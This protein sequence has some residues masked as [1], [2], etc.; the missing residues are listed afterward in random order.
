MMVKSGE[1]Y[2]LELRRKLF[3]CH[4][5]MN[6]HTLKAPPWQIAQYQ[7]P[8]L[9]QLQ[10]PSW[11][12][13]TR[14]V[15]VFCFH[16]R[17][18]MYLSVCPLVCASCLSLQQILLHVHL[19]KSA[20]SHS[21][22]VRVSAEDE[23]QRVCRKVWE[24]RS[25]GKSVCVRGSTCSHSLSRVPWHGS[26]NNPLGWGRE[27]VSVEALMYWGGKGCPAPPTSYSSDW[28]H[29]R[30]TLNHQESLSPLHT[31]QHPW[32]C[33]C[34]CS[35]YMWAQRGG[36]SE[37]LEAFSF[38]PGSNVTGVVQ[39]KFLAAWVWSCRNL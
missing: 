30:V 11:W 14:F 7:D 12:R 24:R 18:Q 21:T 6:T 3:Q 5:G 10:Y 35:A 38:S 13:K 20:W 8:C 2:N 32:V 28:Q 15:C 31:H 22:S 33:C 1:K 36:V 16:Y 34:E 26:K 29:N 37:S 9:P 25:W 4:L 17:V 39:G 23:C 27:G 19:V